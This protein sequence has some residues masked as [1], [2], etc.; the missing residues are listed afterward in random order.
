MTGTLDDNAPIQLIDEVVV[1]GGTEK[2]H[3][4]WPTAEVAANGDLVVVYRSGRDHHITNDGTLCMARSSDGGKTWPFK[5]AIAAEPGWN[6]YTNHGMTRLGNGSLLLHYVRGKRLETAD[7]ARSFYSRGRFTLSLDNGSSW[8]EHSQELDFPFLSPSERGFCYGKLQE[9]PGG[10]FMSPFYGVPQNSQDG[11]NRVL[12][13]VFSSDGGRTWPDYTII[14]QDVRGDINPSETDLIR[15]PDGRF[16]AVIRANATGHLYRS[17][18]ADEGQ[19]WSDLEPTP[20]PGHCPALLRLAS[21]AILCAYRNVDKDQPGM[22]CAVS[23]DDGQT[24]QSLG[25]LYK[26]TNLDCAYPSL[27]RLP[28]DRIFCAFYT[29]MEKDGSG[30]N[31]DIRGLLIEDRS[32]TK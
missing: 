11:S 20:M 26:G 24:W 2:W 27:V 9:L 19:T 15:L 18:S 10:R 8:Q 13:V 22:S 1:D 29:S 17:F 25:F 14:Y 28:D 32:S 3:R 23:D 4:A 31:C 16:L 5:R 7:A 21:G 6:T 30:Q 12:A